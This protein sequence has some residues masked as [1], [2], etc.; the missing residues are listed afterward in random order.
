MFV[1]DTVWVQLG[2]FNRVNKPVPKDII[3]FPRVDEI[4][5]NHCCIWLFLF[6]EASLIQFH[7]HQFF[8]SKTSAN[9]MTFE[10]K[11]E[12]YNLFEKLDRF[13][14]NSNIKLGL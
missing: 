13:S 6:S 11:E 3:L 12:Y 5:K 1:L 7:L 10:S 14:E 4:D 8:S 2:H 9:E